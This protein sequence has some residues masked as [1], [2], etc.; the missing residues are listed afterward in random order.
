ML[1]DAREDLTAFASFPVAH[2]TKIW[3]TNPKEV[4]R[5]TAEL[6]TTE[7]PAPSTSLRFTTTPSFPPLHGTRPRFPS[8]RRTVRG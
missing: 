2:W 4:K 5:A 1:A 8:S 6:V 3:S 7:R